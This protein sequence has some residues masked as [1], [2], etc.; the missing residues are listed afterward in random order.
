MMYNTLKGIQNKAR[1]LPSRGLQSNMEK[2]NK[3]MNDH[4]VN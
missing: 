2:I 1:A 3:H 4:N